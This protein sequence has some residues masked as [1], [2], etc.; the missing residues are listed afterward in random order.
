MLGFF[1]DKVK[2][3]TSLIGFRKLSTVNKE[4]DQ[5]SNSE[6]DFIDFN[7]DDF[8]VAAR[9][10]LS[11]LSS[12]SEINPI[13]QLLIA[14]I[15]GKPQD[16]MEP[17]M[18]TSVFNADCENFSQGDCTQN[19]CLEAEPRLDDQNDHSEEDIDQEL[20]I[21]LPDGMHY[22]D[23]DDDRTLTL[24]SIN[25]NS[26]VDEKRDVPQS[27]ALIVHPDAV[28][29][30]SDK[31]EVCPRL[32]RADG[33][34]MPRHR[35][36]EYVYRK[37][38]ITLTALDA[39]SREQAIT[40][41][42]IGQILVANGLLTDRDRVAAILAVS[43]E[44]IAQENVARSQVPTDILDEYNIM[45]SAETE[46]A[47][48][49]STLSDEQLVSEIIGEYY[50]D[51]DIE[52]VSFPP[53]A[54][55]NF[56]SQ[57]KKSSSIDDS[58]D[59]KE[60]LLDKILYRA[61]NEKASDI[62]IM[63]RRKSYTVMFRTRGV[64]KIVYEGDLDE[65]KTMLAQI[66][67]RS[68]MDLAERRKPQ[69]GGF[70]I[71]YAGKM[72]DLRVAT[73]PAT[74][75]EVV[76]LRVL[77]PD[78]VQPRL[79]QLGITDVEKWRKGFSHQHG[80][81]LICGP[82]GSGKTTTLNS[83]VKEMDRFGKAIYTIEDPVEY[84]I[85]YVNQISVNNSVGLNFATA[86]RSFMRADPDVIILGEVRDEETARNAIKAADTGHLVLATLHTG[87]IVGAVSRLKDLGIAP[88]ELRYLLRSVLVQ[89]LVRTVC[90]GCQGTGLIRETDVCPH[91]R[92][93][94][95][96]GQTVVSECEY[97]ANPEEVDRILS[98]N[99][100]DEDRTWPTMVEDA[101]MKMKQG[102]T[103]EVELRRAFGA[104]A[105]MYLK[106]G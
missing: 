71:E 102:V 35:F 87:S 9:A 16:H 49:V 45:I 28:K 68:R 2:K 24:P 82:T 39:A 72:I 15:S 58:V 11:Q 76:I 18:Q 34:E 12:P 60:L 59:S 40:G 4:I 46:D 66:K 44:R 85:P 25:E 19:E 56:I 55:N 100:T 20:E 74:E 65:H 6:K 23:H 104:G 13:R 37:G 77:D 63:P 67:D 22:E 90:K 84:R 31:Q 26:E 54:I 7:F 80:L 91:C 86:I 64:R 103:D 105:E 5:D 53:N 79:A 89:S 17:G 48:F 95:Y 30:A 99:E 52:F 78:R 75:G 1:S 38:L 10:R 73:V 51:K 57:M 97:F 29:N 32:F 94:R 42:R 106:G 101:V 69:D 83:S 14:Q 33:S 61:L 27:T 93:E 47:V 70:Q 3:V 50:L 98:A 88:R 21:V 43:S 96:G 41:E 8:E 92:G 62:H 81:C 36:G